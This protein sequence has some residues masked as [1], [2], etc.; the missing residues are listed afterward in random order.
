MQQRHSTTKWLSLLDDARNWDCFVAAYQTTEFRQCLGHLRGWGFSA[1]DVRAA[2]PHMHL[3]DT[4]LH[5]A[6]AFARAYG[7]RVTDIQDGVVVEFT[8]TA[9]TAQTVLI[10]LQRA[11]PDL[12]VH[13]GGGGGGTLSFRTMKRGPQL[14]FNGMTAFLRMTRHHRTAQ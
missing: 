4:E 13:I 12:N 2:S 3:T 11:L 10:D 1:A 7:M 5:R 14:T 6:F 9:S 8:T